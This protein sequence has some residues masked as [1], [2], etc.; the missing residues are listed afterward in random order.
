M[1]SL[2]YAG[3]GEVRIENL[4]T[5]SIGADQALVRIQASA[6]CGSERGALTGG[7]IGNAGH[8]AAGVIEALT[9]ADSHFRVGQLVGMAAVTGCGRCDRC[10]AGRET[11]CRR[12][13]KVGGGW[14]AEYAVVGVGALRAV[15][16]QDPTGAALMS[17]DAL[18]VP[19]RVARRFPPSAGAEVVVIGLGPVGLGHVVVQ[20]FAGARVI[21]IEPSAARRRQ[22]LRL[23]A[24]ETY[25]PGQYHGRPA[26]V[27]ECTGVPAAVEGAFE[28][29]DSSG[30]V[31]QSGECQAPVKLVPSDLVVHREVTYTGSWFYASEDYPFMTG[32]LAQGL[33]LRDLCTHEVRPEDAQAAFGD[34][35]NGLTGKVVVRW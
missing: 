21:G 8:E 30:L 23:G 9:A 10:T 24:A 3:G 13:A 32:L 14:H 7:M 6:L 31:I 34:F 18:G 33:P 1:R 27:I 2:R 4:A 22:A 5:P 25:E 17:G 20:T 12:G 26:T 19:A 16:G 28:L 35:V 29:V 11:Q 15:D